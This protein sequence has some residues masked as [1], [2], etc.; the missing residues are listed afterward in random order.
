MN[1]NQ[2]GEIISSLSGD[3]SPYVDL[4]REDAASCSYFQAAQVLYLLSLKQN[5]PD[6][7]A[8]EL[9]RVVFLLPNRRYLYTILQKG[10]NKVAKE[11]PES[12]LEP[13]AVGDKV[14]HEGKNGQVL[15]PVE[16]AKLP[17]AVE[18]WNLQE[19][20]SEDD[21][22]ELI[23][24]PENE[25]ESMEAENG[26]PDL[27]DQFLNNVPNIQRNT[28][29]PV[30]GEKFENEDISLGSVSEPEELAT[31]QLAQIYIQQRYFDKAIEVYK[32]LSLKYPE[33]SIYFASQIEKINQGLNH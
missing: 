12:P 20:G 7:F 29:P 23:A 16:V 28:T 26:T 21:I 13:P 1:S 27:I 17:G 18:N 4:L 2:F 19:F 32:K 5:N 25:S 6:L 31:E 33:K 9:E 24:D 11:V 8:K 22:L 30:P 10:I 14:G 3:L 15:S